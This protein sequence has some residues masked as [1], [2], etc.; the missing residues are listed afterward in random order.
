MS[1]ISTDPAMTER[2][3]AEKLSELLLREGIGPSC[4]PEVIMRIFEN[5]WGKLSVLGHSLHNA[6]ERK[7][8]RRAELLK[9]SQGLLLQNWTEEGMVP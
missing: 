8:A 6:Q 1:I 2:A 4:L 5:H 3:A 7:R 9:T